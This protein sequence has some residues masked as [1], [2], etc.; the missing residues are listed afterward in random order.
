MGE[1]TY[2]PIYKEVEKKNTVICGVN[3]VT[4]PDEDKNERKKLRIKQGN[5]STD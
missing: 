1:F 4:D 3:H 5:S 2:H